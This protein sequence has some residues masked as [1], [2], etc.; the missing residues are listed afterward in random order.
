MLMPSRNIFL[1]FGVVA[2]F[3]LGIFLTI[4]KDPEIKNYPS[5]GTDIIAFG[6]S[7]VSGVGSSRDGGF[8]DLLSQKIGRE[9]INLGVPGNTTE[10]GLKR[11]SQLDK[12]KPK[13]VII[14]LGGNDH[15]RKVPIDTTFENLE[16]L[17]R[18]IQDRGAVVLLLGVKG[19]LFGDKF[20]SRFEDLSEKYGTAYVPDVLSGLFGNPK[21]MSDAIHPNDLG[22]TKIT[23][24]IYP[25]F[26]SLIN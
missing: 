10:D 8:V 11:L 22:Y 6:D 18:G 24:K 25:V 19:N 17:V 5:N 21:Y 12:Y 14:L 4:D 26:L 20:K 2:L 9:I 15:L 7:L 13:V 1:I 23:D 16:T 3:G